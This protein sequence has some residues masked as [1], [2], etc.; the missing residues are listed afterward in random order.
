MRWSL[1]VKIELALAPHWYMLGVTFFP[2]LMSEGLGD[3]HGDSGIGLRCEGLGF[4]Q[5][6]SGKVLR[7]MGLGVVHGG[8]ENV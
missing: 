7:S 2:G 8:V 5:G 6:A 4:V 3:V 1:H